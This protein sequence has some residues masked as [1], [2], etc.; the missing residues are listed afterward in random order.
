MQSLPEH[1][2]D[3]AIYKNLMYV[4]EE[5]ILKSWKVNTESFFF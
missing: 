2:V 4:F 5:P 3:I 1:I